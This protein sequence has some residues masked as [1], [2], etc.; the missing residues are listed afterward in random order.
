MEALRQTRGLASLY[1]DRVT[2]TSDPWAAVKHADAVYTDAATC[3][4]HNRQ[5]ISKDS[6]PLMSPCESLSELM[7]V[8]MPETLFMGWQPSHKEKPENLLHVGK[9]LLVHMLC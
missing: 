4:R 2:I 3:E 7:S 6:T 9:S 5:G 8:A 1:G